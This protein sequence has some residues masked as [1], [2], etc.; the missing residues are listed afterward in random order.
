MLDA[1]I[2]RPTAR[3][4]FAASFRSKTPQQLC[5]QFVDVHA[6][7]EVSDVLEAL[8][9]DTVEASRDGRVGAVLC[10]VGVGG[11]PLL[12]TIHK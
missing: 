10:H 5:G 8:A 2:H 9:E 7:G 4:R 11:S 1:T 6:S 12:G 3:S